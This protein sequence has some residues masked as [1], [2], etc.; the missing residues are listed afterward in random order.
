VPTKKWI[1]PLFIVLCV[2]GVV[3][4][5][6]GI[7]YLTVKANSLPSFWPGHVETR[8]T[9]KTHRALPTSA[10][11][12]RGLVAI[13]LAIASFIGAYWVLFR[14]KPADEKV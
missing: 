1:V 6:V 3:F 14:Y 12:K 11:T 2:I 4:L 5:V 7:V 13:V 8:Y 9:K 10:H